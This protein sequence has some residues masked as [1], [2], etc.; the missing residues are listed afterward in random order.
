MTPQMAVD[1]KHLP[2]CGHAWCERGESSRVARTWHGSG[3]QGPRTDSCCTEDHSVLWRRQRPRQGDGCRLAVQRVPGRVRIQ[4]HHALP[5][6]APLFLST[7]QGHGPM[8]P[9]R[10]AALGKQIP[11]FAVRQRGPNGRLQRDGVA[12]SMHPSCLRVVS[13][14]VALARQTGGRRTARHDCALSCPRLA[15]RRL[16]GLDDPRAG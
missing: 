9:R 13:Q 11:R 2:G 14:R 3:P 8:K 10:M 15:V 4:T 1:G 6:L 5:W 16:P 7:S 12:L